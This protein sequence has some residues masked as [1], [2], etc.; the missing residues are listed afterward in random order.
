MMHKRVSKDVEIR[1][2]QLSV[3]PIDELTQLLNISYKQLS[4]L[5][6]RYLAS[7]QDSTV[8]RQRIEGAYCLIALSKG[9]IIGTISFYQPGIKHGCSWYENK[10]VG[11]VGQFAV[12]PDYQ[13]TGIGSLLLNRTEAFASEKGIKELALDTAEQATHLRSLYEK[14]GYRFIEYV[15]W[16]VTN[17]RSVIMS[18][19]LSIAEEVTQ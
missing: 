18:K 15:S 7:H 10:N 14:K 1:P 12:L 16:D 2:F 8:T 4:D 6:L 11:V 13:G 19:A 3:D 9:N 17:Y 5:G